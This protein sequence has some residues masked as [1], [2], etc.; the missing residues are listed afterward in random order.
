MKIKFEINFFEY[1]K[2]Q[3]IN[4]DCD[5]FDVPIDT[6]WRRRIKDKTCSVCNAEKKNEKIKTK[7]E[8]KKNKGEIS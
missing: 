8:S 2:D 3:I 4:I 5:G 6:Y 1:K 7:I